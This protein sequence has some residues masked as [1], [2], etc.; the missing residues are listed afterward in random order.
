M[1]KLMAFKSFV[2]SVALVCG[3]VSSSLATTYTW[4]GGASGSWCES[5]NWLADGGMGVW[6]QAHDDEHPIEGVRFENVTGYGPV[7][8][9]GKTEFE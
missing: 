5:A 1:K 4:N 3:A 7:T 9:L 6:L 8:R 2:V